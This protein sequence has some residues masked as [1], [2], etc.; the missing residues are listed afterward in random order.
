MT[1]DSDFLPR[2]AARSSARRL[3]FVAFEG[4]DPLDLTGPLGVFT[5]AERQRPGSYDILVA[6]TQGLPL[7]TSSPLWLCGV[8]PLSEVTGDIDTLVVVGGEEQAIRR[9]ACDEGLVRWLRE[10]AP[11]ARRVCSICTGAFILGAAGLLDGRQVTTH[12]AATEALQSYFPKAA[13]DTD[14][15]YR[16]DGRLWTSAGVTTG[17][18]LALALVQADLGRTVA[19]DIARDLVVFVHRCGEQ[20]QVSSTLRAQAAG[21][22]LFDQLLVWMLDHP[23]EDLRVPALAE[24]AA[25]SPRNFAR[26]FLRETGKTPARYVLE[27]R[28]DH[29]CRHLE[30]TSWPMERVAQHSGLGTSEALHRV[31]R[32]QLGM[33]PGMYRHRLRTIA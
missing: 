26:R 25:M 15:L 4:A 11:R 5:R 28:L 18:D 29:A 23:Q 22:G 10:C 27:M 33:T 2:Q 3:V 30:Q 31:F 1:E 7:R 16:T 19:N 20:R 8:Q 14:A 9:A 13:V 32:Q 12:W 21:T 17:I 6:S 24:R